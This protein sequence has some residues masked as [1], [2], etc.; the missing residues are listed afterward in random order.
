MP[1]APD[2]TAAEPSAPAPQQPDAVTSE[3]QQPEGCGRQR[4]L[5]L[6][7][8]C[9]PSPIRP[10]SPLPLPQRKLVNAFL[11]NNWGYDADRMW[12]V[13]A[14]LKTPADGVSKV[15]VLVG[16]KTGKQKPQV[17]AF[18]YLPDGKHIITR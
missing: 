10:I 5:R 15:I 17:L 7:R 6:G 13:Q 2:N 14:I 12:Q 4:R 16:D 3:D 9:F 1:P 11:Q 8:Q 18:F